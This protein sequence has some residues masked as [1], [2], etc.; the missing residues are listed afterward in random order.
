[1]GKILFILKYILL[2]VCIGCLAI[3]IQS[4]NIDAIGGWT[5][6]TIMTCLFDL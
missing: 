1:M 4:N 3:A 2:G 5:V 6:A